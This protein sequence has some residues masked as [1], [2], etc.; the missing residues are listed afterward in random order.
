MSLDKKRILLDWEH[1]KLSIRRQCRLLRI[2]RSGMYYTPCTES[3]ENLAYMRLIDQIYTSHPF[4]GQRQICDQLFLQ[5]FQVG[6]KRI[7]RL[8]KLMRISAIVPGPNTSSPRI[9]NLKYPY[10]LKYLHINRPNMVWATDITYIPMERGFLYLVAIIDW[11]SRYVISWRLS[12]SLESTFCIEALLESLSKGK[13]QIFNSDQ[14]SQFTSDSWLETLAQADVRP[15]MDAKGRFLDNIFIER[16]WRTLKYEEI[17]INSYADQN[18]LHGA[19]SRYIRF[20]NYKRPHT[21]LKKLTPA[22]AYGN[23]MVA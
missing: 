10:L 5:G 19:V 11:Y 13:P 16:F 15:S 8:M 2:S 6:R 21:A 17:Y 18:E 9:E 20:Y 14:G 23:K 3:E 1:L 7:R 22:E 12:N 4:M